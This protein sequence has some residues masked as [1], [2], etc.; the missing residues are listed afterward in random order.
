MTVSIKKRHQRKCPSATLSID[1]SWEKPFC[2]FSFRCFILNLQFYILQHT[3]TYY[4]YVYIIPSIVS[5]SISAYTGFFFFNLLHPHLRLSGRP[6]QPQFIYIYISARCV[7]LMLDCIRFLPSLLQLLALLILQ[8]V[9]SVFVCLFSLLL[10]LHLPLYLKADKLLTLW[11]FPPH[12]RT[13]FLILFIQ[14][15]VNI[16]ITPVVLRSPVV[17]N[18]MSNVPKG[19]ARRNK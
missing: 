5:I 13:L 9:P 2:C 3:H 16:Y 6:L 4:I 18:W 19:R 14:M 11:S 7:Q 12:S 8:S 15:Y 17:G 1:F 10:S